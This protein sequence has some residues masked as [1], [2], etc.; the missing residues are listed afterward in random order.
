MPDPAQPSLRFRTLAVA[1]TTATFGL[2][3]VGSIVRA[4]ESG[5][6]CGNAW[7]TCHPGESL[8]SYHAII[9]ISH[10]ALAVASIVLV[11]MLAAAAVRS[12]RHVRRITLPALGAVVLFVGQ[13]VLG[14]LVVKFDLQPGWVT[15]HF[16]T[17]MLLAGLL[18]YV[19]VNAFEE[20]R[21]EVRGV[22]AG[23][24]ERGFART[25]TAA[26][27]AT[28][29]LLL[30][31]AYVR[32]QGAGLAFPDWPLMNGRLVP[33]L[34]GIATTMFVH[35]VL[36]AAVGLLVVYVAVR[37]W[38]VPDG[39]RRV[40]ALATLALGLFL[41]Q[42]MVGAA[43][44]WSGVAPGWKVTHVV[45]SSLVWGTLVAL[46]TTTHAAARSSER[47]VAGR[48]RTAAGRRPLGETTAAY[49]R[50]TKPRIIS[51]L[52]V[53]TVP[54]MV[55][56]Q[57][58]LP[59]LWLVAA[60]LFGGA[61]SAG[62]ANAMNQFFD[63]DIDEVMRR[64]RGRPLPTGSVSPESALTFGYALGAAGFLWLG[65]TVNVLAAALSMAALLF[66]V[67][68]YTL[69]LKR[70]TPQNIVIGGAA[71]AV[72]VLVGW[73]AVNGSVG[74]PAWVMFA[75]VFYWTPPHFWALSMRYT[76]DYAAAK[77][78]MLPVVRGAQETTWNI[79]L[80]SLVL[81][82]VSLL[83]F[84][85]ARMGAIYGVAALALGAAFVWKAVALWRR[86][87]PA[88]AYGLFKYS[89]S[90]LTLLFAAVAV[91]RLVP[92]G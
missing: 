37:A 23:G 60:T 80:Y 40:R 31:G 25:T 13:A 84:P 17:S 7:P 73:A 3:A 62:G 88:L 9:E 42:V 92:L 90:Y 46:A 52:L 19:S 48:M 27:V 71:G 2:I 66:Y 16:A 79:L 35:R 58:G 44:V 8:L 54:A 43:L 47:A 41:A 30:V 69:G 72:P 22:P 82:A 74:L 45:L 39:G 32:G 87:T 49:F 11:A 34:G 36:A 68:V 56:A 6:G 4:T 14:A 51:L 15:A 65:M 86:S 67:L 61:L 12:Y 38:A 53:T 55:L 81:V 83:L 63:R 77:V 10:R 91:D 89:I 5:L 75:V 78:P 26:A 18:V 28:F 1:A 33:Q 59:S 29:A 64:T 21:A 20:D 70:S 50:L 76:A 85:V 57:D 24:S